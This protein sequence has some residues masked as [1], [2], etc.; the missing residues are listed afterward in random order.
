MSFES[1]RLRK[2]IL[3][4][5]SECSSNSNLNEGCSVGYVELDQDKL[6]QSIYSFFILM[7]VCLELNSTL[8]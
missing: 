5:I 6:Q 4:I 3:Q 8:Q 7:Q 1:R 2:H